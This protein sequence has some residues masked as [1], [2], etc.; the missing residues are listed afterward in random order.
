[1]ELLFYRSTAK[2]DQDDDFSRATY[3]GIHVSVVLMVFE[4]EPVGHQYFSSV[5]AEPVEIPQ[6]HRRR[7]FIWSSSEYEPQVK[8]PNVVR[9][10]LARKMLGHTDYKSEYAPQEV[11]YYFLTIFPRCPGIL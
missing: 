7:D 3:F 5:F 2:H 10:G 6:Y 9:H 11:S 1:M 4:P 8:C